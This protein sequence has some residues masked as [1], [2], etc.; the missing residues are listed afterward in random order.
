LTKNMDKEFA[1]GNLLKLLIKLSIPAIVA[2]LINALYN[3]VDRM[4]LGHIPE[5]GTL[6]LTGVGLTFP[7]ILLVSAFSALIGMGGAPLTSIALGKGDRR[8]AEKLLGNS[9]VTLVGISVILTSVFLIFKRPLLYQFGASD[10]TIGYAESY[11]TIY[12][13][14]T[15]FV[16]LSL[17]LNNFINAQ[18]FAK[19]GMLTVL[20]GAV[21]NIVLDP[22]LIFGFRMG[23]QGAALATILSQFVSAL[24]VLK[25]LFG[26]KTGIRIRTKYFKVDFRLL[27]KITA[28]GMAPFIM[29]STESLVQ[30]TLNTNL[31]LYGSD[32]YVG[33]MTIL[34]STIQIF[35]LPLQG[36]TQ[37]AQPIIGYNFGA[38]NYDRVKKT[39]KYSFTLCMTASVLACL[40]IELFPRVIIRIFS[41]DPALMDIAVV[42]MRIFMIGTFLMGAQVSLQNAFIAMGRAKTAICMALLRKIVLLIPLAILLPKF[43]GV[44][45]VF[46]AEP[47]SDITAALTTTT[48]FLLS[49]GRICRD[50]S[51]PEKQQ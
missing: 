15:L 40:L 38:K 8:E 35:T 4:Y 28:L 34:S 51:A 31:R 30:I 11:L 49:I 39:V 23:V 20:I 27:G 43:L 16:Q 29:Q 17:G 26:K 41:S 50:G 12:L 6:A 5:E 1:E 9:F 25:F 42:S 3:I 33:A 18:G 32:L 36:F 21:T 22:I 46:I 13:I 24:W 19:T 47:I 48:V 37:G 45:G 44:D 7:I 2:Q 14:G 10:D